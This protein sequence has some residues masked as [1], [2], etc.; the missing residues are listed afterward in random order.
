MKE[1][2]SLKKLHRRIMTSEAYRRA[3]VVTPEQ[4][5]ADP[6]NRY[7]GRF[8]ARRL[9][10]EEIRDAM[11]V[12][13]DRLDTL[14]GGPAMTDMGSSR[15][16]LYLQTCRWDRSNF[17]TLFDAANPDASVEKRTT[18]TVAPQALFLLNDTFVLN[19]ASAIADRLLRDVPKREHETARIQHAYRLLFAR[20]AGT[21]EIEQ[22]KK[23]L[24]RAEKPGEDQAWQDWVHVLLCSNEFVYLE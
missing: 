20:Q 11:L 6:D 23:F 5:A 4:L 24:A 13:A 14:R 15:R 2:W 9:D 21:A 8:N 1:G 18:S 3:S 16:S 12:A 17:A 10:A 19:Q 22:A 7:L